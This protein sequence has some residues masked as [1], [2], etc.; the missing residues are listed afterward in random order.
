VQPVGSADQ[1]LEET[2][3]TQADGK[4]TLQFT[5]KLV[6]DGEVA[7]I[8][9]A[10]IRFNW[11]V[12]SSNALGFHALY[13]SNITMFTTC[14]ET[15]PST[16]SPTSA[17][18][19]QIIPATQAPAAPTKLDCSFLGYVNV[20]EDGSLILR[21]II[22]PVEQTV[23][24]ELEYFGAAWLGFAFSETAAMVPNIAVL[25][26]PD[27]QS[28]QKYNLTGK[29]ADL[30]VPLDAAYQTLT[31]ASIKQ[32]DSST[33][34][35][36]TKKLVEDNE[37]TVKS[38]ENRFNWAIGGSNDFPAI[39]LRK[40]SMTLA[41]D[42]C[43]AGV[44]QTVAPSYTPSYAPSW[45][46]QANVTNPPTQYRY[47]TNAPSWSPTAW[48][49]QAKQVYPTLPPTYA[50]TNKSTWPPTYSPTS[51]PTYTQTDRP[52]RSPTYKPTNYPTQYPTAYPA[53]GTW[54]KRGNRR[55]CSRSVCPSAPWTGGQYADNGSICRNGLDTSY[56]DVASP[57][58]YEYFTDVEM[59]TTGTQGLWKMWAKGKELPLGWGS[60]FA[61]ESDC[62]DDPLRGGFRV[63]LTGSGGFSFAQQAYVKV[64]GWSPVIKMVTDGKYVGEWHQPGSTGEHTM[65]I[66]T[67]TKVLEVMCGGWPAECS[68]ELYVTKPWNSG[69][70][71]GPSPAYGY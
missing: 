36:F 19:S 52:T 33:L 44:N 29:Q 51:S 32:T 22:N 70:N 21:Q 47:V 28:V 15:P 11:A 9:D 58:T 48:P 31:D 1:T 6:E 39:H 63:D 38:G 13:G 60:D 23:Y 46:P 54:S 41:F 3:I 34:L 40:G 66:P 2:S 56:W 68:S 24:V 64:T 17:P 61:S 55:A 62:F 7:I 71:P 26:L 57:T 53:S 20:T 49:T 8:G 30:V 50:R 12:G 42:E 10:P 5:K 35:K 59:Q 4:T 69:Q 18:V 43:R 27:T 45:S 25:G 14:P 65:W 67:G 16:A 37:I